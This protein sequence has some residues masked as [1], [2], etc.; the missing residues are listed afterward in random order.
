MSRHHRYHRRHRTT[1]RQTP[2]GEIPN[3]NG[4]VV[5]L[6]RKLVETTESL[7][8][9]NQQVVVKIDNLG[10]KIDNLGNKIDDLST[11]LGTKIDDLNAKMNTLTN[12]VRNIRGELSEAAL[13]KMF[14]EDLQA[15]GYSV[16]VNPIGVIRG[17]KV[18]YTIEARKGRKKRTLYVEVRTAIAPSSLEKIKRKFKGIEGEKWV[19]SRFIDS[20]ALEE[21]KNT[22][23]NIFSYDDTAK[24]IRVLHAV[25]DSILPQPTQPTQPDTTAT[26][27]N[28]DGADTPD[29]PDT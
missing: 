13:L 16:E 7:V 9:I 17:D 5:K 21:L 20:I 26:P 19:L 1:Q 27:D 11:N 12:H 22:D 29:N 3:P 14:I 4:E 18:D 8:E 10:G 6:L 15:A 28:P 25:K 2:A 24:S 23:I